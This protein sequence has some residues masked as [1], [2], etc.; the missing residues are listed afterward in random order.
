MALYSGRGITFG[1][2]FDSGVYFFVIIISSSCELHRLVR[3]NRQR[4]RIN[5]FYYITIKQFPAPYLSAVL[6][7]CCMTI[8]RVKNILDKSRAM[9]VLFLI[10]RSLKRMVMDTSA[11]LAMA[12]SRLTIKYLPVFSYTNF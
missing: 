11:L 4:N 12:R 10:D 8:V 1:C 9:A 2:Y 5:Y 7:K 6:R 3:I